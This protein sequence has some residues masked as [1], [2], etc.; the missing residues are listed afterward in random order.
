[1]KKLSDF[2]GQDH[3]TAVLRKSV[4]L[5]TPFFRICLLG[6]EQ[7]AFEVGRA[8]VRALNCL[9]N[10]AT[11]DA[12]GEC[13]NCV[14]LFPGLTILKWK[15]AYEP[16][17]ESDEPNTVFVKTTYDAKYLAF[18]LNPKIAFF[19]DPLVLKLFVASL[20][21][22]TVDVINLSEEIQSKLSTTEFISSYVNLV[23]TLVYVKNNV[24]VFVEDKSS[25]AIHKLA[26][27]VP[28]YKLHSVMKHLWEAGPKASFLS[29]SDVLINAILIAEILH[30]T[31]KTEIT[32]DE[33]PINVVETTVKEQSLDLEQMLKMAHE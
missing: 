29:P 33:A 32:S 23:K 19:F 7:L 10:K 2:V 18:N 30:P 4:A 22:K 26:A 16:T 21:G 14:N 24:E 5:N 12:C 20:L 27:A 8:Y 1:M 6:D 11:G 25:E 31:D 15:L 28:T 13:E 17:E 3:L 9:H